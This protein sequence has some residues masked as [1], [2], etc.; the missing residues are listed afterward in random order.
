[1]R[2][3]VIFLFL[4]IFNILQ[5]QT[6]SQE[7]RI[8]D[9]SH[10]WKDVSNY[11]HTPEYL[12]KIKWDSLYYAYIPQVSSCFND[13]EY[14]LLL[15]RFLANIGDGHTEIFNL[16][17]YL[18]NCHSAASLP[19]IVQWIGADLYIT[20][21]IKLIE[22]K[23]P[24]GSKI[25]QI[26]NSIPEEY[27]NNHV[28]PYICSK[29]IQDKKK[30][31]AEL[32]TFIKE[33]GDSIFLSFETPTGEKR[34]Q[35]FKYTNQKRYKHD[36]SL[37][38]P[39]IGIPQ[40]SYFPIKEDKKN[41]YYFRFDN[42]LNSNLNIINFEAIN[43][44]DY[45]VLDLRNNIGGSELFADSL[46]M[47]FLRTDTLFTYKSTTRISNAYYTAMGYGY[48]QYKDYYLEQ[49]KQILAGDTLIR[50]DWPYIDK[51]LFI[52]IS[53]NT[54]SAAEDFLITLKVNFPKRA[55]LVGTPTAGAT[56]APLVKKLSNGYL[57]RICTRCPLVPDGLFDNGIQP[58]Y[59]FIPTIQNL[60]N[61]K[62]DILNFVHKLYIRQQ[63][64]PSLSTDA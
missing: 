7:Q 53:E 18:W 6:I 29:T 12:H 60:I 63:H 40:T 14:M 8:R 11:Y 31:A 64:H 19:F 35:W 5:A 54:C 36:Y 20:G 15:Q 55:I 22:K 39:N 17:R 41:F 25:T 1:M 2:T 50:P 58:D 23:I 57:Y 3:K 28:Y 56:G 9:L 46:L 30:K 48:E 27:F 45:V 10:I 24:L 38:D 43:Q 33:N 47:N 26:N 59:I 42:F 16:N 44:C 21:A 62:D 32:F 49:K 4:F 34:E 52:L 61:K 13:R 51:P 37:I